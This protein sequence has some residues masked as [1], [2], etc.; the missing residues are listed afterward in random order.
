MY[1]RG[2]TCAS[3]R[4]I[5]PARRTMAFSSL[6]T[7]PC[8]AR[9]WAV[10]R[11]HAIP[12]SA[13]CSRYARVGSP[14]FLAGTVTLNPPTSLTASLTPSNTSGWLSTTQWLPSTPPACLLYTS[15]AADDLTR[16]DLGGR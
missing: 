15:D 11:S 13:V 8:P 9:P 10:I 3:I 12:F 14:V 4:P 16:V 5:A 6:G 7:D 2:H 1:S